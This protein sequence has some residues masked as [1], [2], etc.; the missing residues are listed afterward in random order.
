MASSVL[1]QVA[2][3]SLMTL[4]ALLERKVSYNRPSRESF[5]SNVTLDHDIDILGALDVP[6]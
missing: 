5:F 6:K 3:L 1:A 4:K 2:F